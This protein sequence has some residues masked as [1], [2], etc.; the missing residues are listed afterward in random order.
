[1][2]LSEKYQVFDQVYG[3]VVLHAFVVLF[4]DSEKQTFFNIRLIEN[5][6][7]LCES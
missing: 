2:L 4:I 5:V 6:H 3:S 7:Y 1:M